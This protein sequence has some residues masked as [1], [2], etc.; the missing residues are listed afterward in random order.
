MRIGDATFMPIRK[1]AKTVLLID[2]NPVLADVLSTKLNETGD[3]SCSFQKSDSNLIGM[4]RTLRPD[5]M[6]LDPMHLE[7]DR[8]F[9]LADFGRAIRSASPQTRLLGYSFKVSDTLLRAALDAGFRGCVSKGSDFTQVEIAISAVLAGG[10]FFDQ[11]FGSHLRPVLRETPDSHGLSDRE[12]DVL[13][14]L[15]RGMS[16]K[17]IAQQLDISN[18]T[19]DTYKARACKKLDLSDRARI[20]EYVHDQGWLE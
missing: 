9:D 14:G 1:A 4:T 13:V 5:V 15:A 20:V 10:I 19:V 18:K 16:S 2:K 12:K 7:L 17:Q 6:F 8:D 3:I 11:G